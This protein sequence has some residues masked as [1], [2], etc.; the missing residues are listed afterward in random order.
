MSSV[1]AL[2][3]AQGPRRSISTS[4]ARNATTQHS[5]ASSKGDQASSP[6]STPRIT[7]S[8]SSISS[9]DQTRRTR[10]VPRASNVSLSKVPG[11]RRRASQQGLRNKATQRVTTSIRQS[12]V[13]RIRKRASK[14]DSW[15]TLHEYIER[16]SRSHTD[17]EIPAAGTNPLAQ[18]TETDAGTNTGTFIDKLAARRDEET[19]YSHKNLNVPA[20]G[21]TPKAEDRGT[22]AGS[23][24]DVFAGMLSARRSDDGKRQKQ[25]ADTSGVSADILAP[26]LKP[27]SKAQGGKTIS[28]VD[29]FAD[30]FATRRDDDPKRQK[31]DKNPY[32]AFAGIQAPGTKATSKG[33]G[34]STTSTGDQFA[35]KFAARRD[36]DQKRQESRKSLSG[37]F[38]D[39]FSGRN[40]E[41]GRETAQE[42]ERRRWTGERSNK[43][44]EHQDKSRMKQRIRDISH[45]RLE[46]SNKEQQE[47]STADLEIPRPEEEVR[48]QGEPAH[49][50]TLGEDSSK[51]AFEIPAIEE[52]TK[53]MATGLTRSWRGHGPSWFI[54]SCVSGHPD[55]HAWRME[56]AKMRTVRPSIIAL[57]L[58]IRRDAIRLGKTAQQRSLLQQLPHG[59][60]RRQMIEKMA[61]IGMTR[62]ALN[63]AAHVMEATSDEERCRRLLAQPGPKPIWLLNFLLRPGSTLQSPQALSD[64]IA[65]CT[66][67]YDGLQSRDLSFEIAAYLN[68]PKRKSAL[69]D[70]YPEDVAHLVL[71]L[72]MRAMVVDAR[73]LPRIAQLAAQYIENMGNSESEKHPGEIFYDQCGL[74]NAALAAFR[75]SKQRLPSTWY[76]WIPSHWDAQRVLLNMSTSLSR[77]LLVDKLGYRSVREVLSGL[78][79]DQKEVHNS[80][81]HRETWPPYLEP[82]DGIDE[83]S[84]PDANWS[85]SVSAATLQQESG[86]HLDQQDKVLDILQGRSPDTRPTI[87]QRIIN[88]PH[89]DVQPWEASIRATRNVQEAWDR[90][91]NPPEPGMEPGPYE[92]GAMLTKLLTPHARFDSTELPGDSARN[93]PGKEDPNLTEFEKS[94][95]RAPTASRLRRQMQR[96]NIKPSEATLNMLISSN[97]RSRR[98]VK[99]I[100][101]LSGLGKDRYV[102]LLAGH[103]SGYK[104][105]QSVPL[106]LFVAF[107]KHIS[108]LKPVSAQLLL[109]GMRM[110]EARFAHDEEGRPWAQHC[111]GMLLKACARRPADPRSLPKSL[112]PQINTYHYVA[113]AIEGGG[114]LKLPQVMEFASCA[115]KAARR[116]LAVYFEDIELEDFSAISTL[117]ALYGHDDRRISFEERM[118]VVDPEHV[119]MLRSVHH[120]STR[121]NEMIQSLVER[122]QKVHSV[123]AGLWTESLDGVRARG[124]AVRAPQA[125]TLVWTWAFLGEYEEMARYLEWLVE[126]WDSS[127]ICE[128]MQ[129]YRYLPV[130]FDF[131]ITLCIFRRYAEPM[132]PEERVEELRRKIEEAQV[133]WEWPTAATI[134]VNLRED[135]IHYT[136][137]LHVQQWTRYWQAK[138]RGEDMS[139]IMRPKRWSE[140]GTV[141]RA[142]FD[143]EPRVA[144]TSSEGNMWSRL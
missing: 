113:D 126:Q 12:R 54:H 17:L 78:D 29:Q 31:P 100:L 118:A 76:R 134:D 45:P 127:V 120:M 85:R 47:I 71:L 108:L 137:L 50:D 140:Y 63:S 48:M 23:S 39:I 62:D 96:K 139:T 4:R 128:E 41:K 133:V 114:Y 87:Q 81:R 101:N 43:E 82:G 86:F 110:C 94:R 77:P 69:V 3:T 61:A 135:R 6:P 97:R 9:N 26:P 59:K 112:V 49:E 119:A 142:W 5:A 44:S 138:E 42:F 14:I 15:N 73:L 136:R 27:P 40:L 102:P 95:M 88:A 56:V 35:D 70:I 109:R 18:H 10:G 58:L 84:D 16:N 79:K 129:M 144:R 20:A 53:D 98:R 99:S 67:T 65:Y 93:Y 33:K 116:I 36:D 55:Q 2:L 107:I 103:T 19:Q 124:D 90:F 72:A 57:Q 143:L 92:Y 34:G 105:L 64:L 122:E 1:I 132:L 115:Q 25:S 75:P 123:L 21:S 89:G 80:L 121:L 83:A 66:H 37:V 24:L 91:R 51:D 28:T 130:P 131:T 60:P 8:P 141:R 11:G 104:G 30:K 125:Q 22:S 52:V 111:W 46:Q 68:D 38:A 7:K 106:S 32:D 117:R 13:L 74:F